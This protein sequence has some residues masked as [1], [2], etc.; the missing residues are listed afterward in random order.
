MMF[1]FSPV[2][3]RGVSVSVAQVHSTRPR[4]LKIK[5]RLLMDDYVAVGKKICAERP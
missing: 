1:T 5:N 4:I 2:V 3:E